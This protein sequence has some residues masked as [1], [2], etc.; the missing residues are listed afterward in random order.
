MKAVKAKIDSLLGNVG[1]KFGE[2][3]WAAVAL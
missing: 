2:T 3:N 1:D